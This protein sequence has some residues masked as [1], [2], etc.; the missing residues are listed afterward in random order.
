MDRVLRLVNSQL[1]DQQKF[2]A[3][4]IAQDIEQWNRMTA[5][6]KLLVEANKRH[7]SILNRKIQDLSAELEQLR[8]LYEN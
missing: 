7:V 2:T 4:V 1:H 5:S 3:Q 6:V 8:A